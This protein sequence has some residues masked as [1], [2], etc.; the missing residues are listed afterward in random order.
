MLQQFAAQ[1]IIAI[2]ISTIYISIVLFKN[3]SGYVKSKYNL[4]Y[5]SCS[6]FFSFTAISLGQLFVSLSKNVKVINGINAAFTLVM[7]F[8]SGVFFPV[9]L[10]P[11]GVVNLSKFMHN[12]ILYTFYKI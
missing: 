6:K 8:S 3:K 5:I 10:L 11:Q 4:Y 2:F 9:R 1:I 7:A 12:I